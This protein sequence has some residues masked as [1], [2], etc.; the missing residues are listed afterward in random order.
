MDR[1]QRGGRELNPNSTPDPKPHSALGMDPLGCVLLI[2][3]VLSR[4]I[5]GGTVGPI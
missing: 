5:I 3:T 1:E 4:T 2:L